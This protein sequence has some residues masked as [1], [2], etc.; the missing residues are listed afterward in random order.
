[1]KVLI[2]GGTGTLGR[3]IVRAALEAG[4]A[5]RI[6]SRHPRPGAAAHA[7]WVRADFATGDGVREAVTGVDAIIHAASDPW[8][9][10][11]VDVAGTR[12]LVEAAREAG[13]GHLVYVSIV[14]VDRIPLRYYRAKA[15]AEQIVAA[16]GMPYS[17]LRATQFHAFVDQLLSA[18][19]RVPLVLP[20]PTD[21]QVQSV[22]AEDV[23]ARLIRALEEGPGKRLPDVGGPETMTVGEAAA[24]W[25]RTRSIQKPILPLPLFGKIAAGFRAGH[26]TVREGTHGSVRWE[27]WL[28]R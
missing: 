1:M 4:H 21:F 15:E 23:A 16:S 8:K 18:A 12:R 22:A 2:T 17:V 14:G 7:E 10:R 25:K 9:P 6:Q 3:R 11:A 5:V 13:I 20:L 24:V 26:N 27:E 28:R 19:A